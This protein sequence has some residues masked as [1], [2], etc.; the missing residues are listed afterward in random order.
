ME[1]IRCPACESE[2]QGEGIGRYQKYTLYW[3]STCDLQW[4]HPL[5]NPG[6][7]FYE[8]TCCISRDA[9]SFVDELSWEHK[10]FFRYL[11]KRKGRLLDIGCRTGQ[12][13]YEIKRRGLAFQTTGLD[14]D[15][16]AIEVAK[17]L[18]GPGNV[19]VMS[20][21]EFC[22]GNSEKD[23]DMVTL[24][25]V[26]EHQW[27]PV[28]F[29]QMVK[30]LLPPGGYVILAVP[31]R[32]MWQAPF[33]WDY[34]PMH[35]TRWS[36]RALR[37]FLEKYGFSVTLILDHPVS[38]PEAR[39]I[40]SERVNL[41]K[42]LESATA[43]GFEKIIVEHR[44]LGNYPALRK[45]TTVG[46]GILRLFRKGVLLAPALLLCTVGRASS[47]KGQEIFCIARKE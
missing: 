13:L 37:F 34:P 6:A 7:S 15:K 31:N 35:L 12:F 16:K 20:L 29:L 39:A 44:N 23:F 28:G 21:E 2:P 36:V 45:L 17:R 1:Y 19:Y 30:E 10:Q 40:I 18:L 43:V 42:Y 24:F 8:E 5:E 41:L 4:W 26:L 46:L 27:D 11:P 47:R 33:Y 38:I 32:D 25:Q 14:F 9:F 22:T 3:C